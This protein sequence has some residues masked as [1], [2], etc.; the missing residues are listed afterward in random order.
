LGFFYLTIEKMVSKAFVVLVLAIAL[1]R[2]A[3]GQ[4]Q[5]HPRRSPLERL[6]NARELMLVDPMALFKLEEYEQDREREA[7]KPGGLAAQGEA[8]RSGPGLNP[9]LATP[10]DPYGALSPGNRSTEDLFGPDAALDP[11]RGFGA[12][13][14]AASRGAGATNGLSVPAA[15]GTARGS[16][17]LAQP[18]AGRAGVKIPEPAAA[19]LKYLGIER[20]NGDFDRSAV[21]AGDLAPPQP[22]V[23]SGAAAKAP[24]APQTSEGSGLL[25]FNPYDANSILAPRQPAPDP[26]ASGATQQPYG[27]PGLASGL[28]PSGALSGGLSGNLNSAGSRSS[29]VL[30]S[31]L[32]SPLSP[33]P[34]G[35]LR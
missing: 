14:N 4:S 26:G 7:G 3:W 15:V 27:A 17:S 2:P 6:N 10:S 25:G 23:V 16:D 29:S 18:G 32:T 34:L 31:S 28:A 1:L 13:H 22:K 9:Y 30:P 35:R 20:D 8:P 33:T 12:P 24:T 5:L 21:E 19:G 11:L